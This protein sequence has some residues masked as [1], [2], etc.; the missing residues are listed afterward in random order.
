MKCFQPL[1][2]NLTPPSGTSVVTEPTLTD[3]F[4]PKESFVCSLT[5]VN[6]KLEP[7][8]LDTNNHGWNSPIA[9]FESDLLDDLNNWT[10]C[11]VPSDIHVCYD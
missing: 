11:Y 2:T 6:E 10:H 5:A 4:F 7:Q 8:K 1:I 3:Y 9:R